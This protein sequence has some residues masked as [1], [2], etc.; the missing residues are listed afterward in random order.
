MEHT[1][2]GEQDLPLKSSTGIPFFYKK[3][4]SDSISEITENIEKE[5]QYSIIDMMIT[6]NDLVDNTY[7]Q[8]LNK[9]NFAFNNNLNFA[10]NN[11]LKENYF[12]I[13]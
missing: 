5:T 9:V 6:N 3:I 4:Y 1:T 7:S 13:F 11:N 10:F 2:I 12:V 8:I